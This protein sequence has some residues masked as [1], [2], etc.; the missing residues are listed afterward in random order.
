MIVSDAVFYDAKAMTAP[1]IAAFLDAQ[2]RACSGP[3]CLKNLRMTTPSKVADKYCAAY[4]GAVNESVATVLA[5]LSV[6]CS[7]N[8]QVML[9]TLQKE[10]APAEPDRGGRVDLCG[11]LR[12][13]LPGHRARRF[14]ELRSAVRRLLQPGRRDGQAM[15]PLSHRPAEIHLPG[16]PAG[17][18]PVERGRVGLRFLQRVH[19][20]HR[21]RVPLQLHALPA[22]RGF[23]GRLPRRR[24]QVQRLRQ[25]KLLLPVPEIFRGDRR[26][27]RGEYR[28]ERGSGHHPGR[29]ARGPRRGGPGHRGPQRRSGPRV[30]RGLRGDRAALCLRRRHR[31]RRRRPGLFAGRGERRTPA[32][33]RLAST[34]PG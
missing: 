13:A 26:R 20:K 10:S 34:A 8:P 23:A 30:G 9:V 7:I 19:P 3:L 17:R 6:A 32:R 18:H 21:D 5:K 11:R 33:A 16:R 29:P 31:R 15:G 27:R 1:Q 24:R 14:G 4:P 25:P 22:E 12:L 28:A 2:G